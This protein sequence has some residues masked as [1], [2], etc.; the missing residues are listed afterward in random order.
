MTLRQPDDDAVWPW[1]G[2]ASPGNP[3]SSRNLSPGSRWWPGRG[4]CWDRRGLRR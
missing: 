4:R 1:P 2:T 3:P